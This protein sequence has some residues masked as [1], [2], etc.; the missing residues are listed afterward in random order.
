MKP[1]PASYAVVDQMLTIPHWDEQ[2]SDP[3]ER[4]WFRLGMA[5]WWERP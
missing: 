5:L 1:S 3:I 4:A 2:F